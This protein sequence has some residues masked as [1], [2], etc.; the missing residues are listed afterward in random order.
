MDACAAGHA[1]SIA[2][3]EPGPFSPQEPAVLSD[4]VATPNPVAVQGSIDVTALASGSAVVVGAEWTLNGSNGAMEPADG[5]F[6]SATEGLYAQL[7][8]PHE[9]GIYDLCVNATDAAAN[10]SDDACI[11]LVVYD[12]SAGFVTGGG[13]IWS[14][15]GALSAD[16]AATGRANFGFV[17]R[18][19]R[20]ANVPDGSTQF[21]FQAGGLNFHS[22]TYDWLVVTG[23]NFARFKGAGTVNGANAETG[24]PYQFMIWA[25]DGNPDTFRIKIWYEDDGEVLVYDNGMDQ[26]IGGGH[27]IIHTGS[28]R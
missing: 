9:A 24:Q 26:S 6:G 14:P 15:P 20:G 2:E 28:Q 23:S 7:M 5:N 11:V 22:N 27:I 4:L 18:Y 17:S 19:R 21:V 16:S 13:W 25:G 8:A 12:P 1:A 10:T 3:I